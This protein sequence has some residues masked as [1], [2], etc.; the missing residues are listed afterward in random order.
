MGKYAAKAN[1]IKII[2]KYLPICRKFKQQFGLQNRSKYQKVHTSKGHKFVV[3]FFFTKWRFSG[4]VH[5]FMS[6]N[7]LS[8]TEIVTNR[9]IE[10]R[11]V[12]IIKNL[13]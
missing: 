6:K 12:N 2:W 7:V 3:M 4:C 11:P 10:H 9:W 5:I 13:S 8:V 1:E